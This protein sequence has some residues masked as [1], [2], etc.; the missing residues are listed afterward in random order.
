M[1]IRIGVLP[2]KQFQEE[3]QQLWY[4]ANI[5]P[6]LFDRIWGFSMGSYL[7]VNLTHAGSDISQG[8]NQINSTSMLSALRR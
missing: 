8:L 2:R 6:K 1:Q 4:L 3:S 7:L 5:D